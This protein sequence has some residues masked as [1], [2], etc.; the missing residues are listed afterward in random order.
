MNEIQFDLT[1]LD[2]LYLL[3]MAFTNT[4]LA[5]GVVVVIWGITHYIHKKLN[6]K[7]NSFQKVLFSISAFAFSFFVGIGMASYELNK[8]IAPVDYS[9]I[10]YEKE[11]TNNP[12]VLRMIDAAVSDNLVTVYEL[13]VLK[14]QTH[15]IE[16]QSGNENQKSALNI[17]ERY[18]EDKAKLLN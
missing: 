7:I 15:L 10:L 11:K 2:P 6:M 18:L 17:N 12:E 13:N 14:Q 8:E 3:K 16:N 1:L 9:Y 4:L 5:L